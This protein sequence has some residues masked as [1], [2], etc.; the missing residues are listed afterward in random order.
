[1][2][3]SNF[4]ILIIFSMYNI[5]GTSCFSYSWFPAVQICFYNE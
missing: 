5:K 2:Y 4:K 1:M 3:Y